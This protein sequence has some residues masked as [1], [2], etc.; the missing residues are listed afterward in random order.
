MPTATAT[1]ETA[2]EMDPVGK[3]AAGLAVMA[4]IA[5]EN[6]AYS[7]DKGYDYLVPPGLELA[8]GQRVVVPFGRGGAQRMGL[9]LEVEDCGEGELPRGLKAVKAAADPEP[10]L[11]GEM[12]RM[13]RWLRGET[14][15][16]WFEGLKALLPGGYAL[17]SRTAWSLCQGEEYDS[18]EV[19]PE[20]ARL[21]GVLAAR[22]APVPEEE[23]LDLLGLRR[24]HPVLRELEGKGLIQAHDQVKRRVLDQ[25]QQMVRLAPGWE[26]GRL[27]PKQQG[28]RELLEQVGCASVKEVCYFAG[29]TKGVVDNFVKAGAGE[30]YEEEVYRDP[31]EDAPRE[32]KEEEI[33][34]SPE[35]EA[36]LEQLEE[37]LRKGDGSTAL[38]FGVTGSGKT[39]VYMKLVD[40]VLLEGDRAIVL[41]PEI[42]LTP[43]TIRKFHRRY[44]RRVAVLHSGLS[45]SQ[46]LDEW[47]RARRG[48]VDVV[49]G[50]RSAVFAPLERLRLIVIDE[51]QEHTYQSE[52]APRYDAREAARARMRMTGGMTLLCSATPSVESY[53]HAKKGD[54]AL[55]ELPRRY[56][57][58]RLPSVTILDMQ[59]QEIPAE[60]LSQEL[61]QEIHENL[62]RGEQ[63]I[64]LMNRRG[65]STQ[66]RCASCHTPVECPNCSITMKYH[67]AN[68]RLMC[69]YCGYSTPVPEKCPACGS[70]FLKYTGLGTQRVEE[71]LRERWPEARI[72]RMDM[73]TTMQRFS[74]EKLLGEFRAGKYDIMVGTQM[75][76]KGLDFPNVTLVGV[77]TVDQMLYSED[78]RS[79]E[80]AFSLVTQV[81]GRCGRDVLPGRAF[82][83]TYT[84]ENPILLAAASQ[85]YKSFY[86]EEIQSR[87]FHLYP[88]FCRLYCVGITGENL[89]DTERGAKE[90]LE[91]MKTRLRE[92]YGDLPVRLLGLSQGSVFRVAGRYRYKILVKTVRSPRSRAFFSELLEEAGR[93]PRGVAVFVDPR[94]DSD[95]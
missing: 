66:V 48:M 57:A 72:L 37:T 70:S 9:V 85:D 79:Y 51:E 8:P 43:Q 69:H 38:L 50:T 94:Y 14:F 36:A 64:L 29:V 26:G 16:T 95:F 52:S 7:F 35:Q 28:V 2:T 4:K 81:V 34:L 21:L 77:L 80:R 15:C 22:K 76:A 73:D 31:Y 88:P 39:Q 10:V 42:S 25:K 68:G 11:D 18:E 84:P 6:A 87:K 41:V 53:Y 46:R 3:G 47:K 13:L 90:L 62:Q 74:H 56:G 61:C 19:S 67:S 65:Y 20:G 78:F 33:L 32:G 91:W 71:V 89:R 63:T 17:K 59:S 40:R 45:M 5:V 75:V 27:T 54:Y 24:G 83:Q 60:G 82:I 55:V 1:T 12:L 93:L 92:G 44:G 49:V 30:Y 23:L 58:A 86:R